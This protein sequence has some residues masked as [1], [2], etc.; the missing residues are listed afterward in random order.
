MIGRTLGLLACGL[1][2]AVRPLAGQVD[3]LIIRP[4][5]TPEATYGEAGQVVQFVDRDLY[6]DLVLPTGSTVEVTRVDGEVIP[7]DSAFTPAYVLALLR[8]CKFPC[9]GGTPGEQR[10]QLALV[11]KILE[12]YP[13]HRDAVEFRALECDLMQPWDGKD[14]PTPAIECAERFIRDYPDD[15]RVDEYVWRI[16]RV[17]NMVYEFE[18][19]V[20]LMRAQAD[21]FEA[22][23][24]DHPD[25]RFADEARWRVAR[26][27]YMMQEVS[28]GEARD[29][30]RA[31]ALELYDSLAESEL[32]WVRLTAVMERFNLEQGRN[33]YVNPN[34]LLVS[35]LVGPF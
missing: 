8:S 18:G 28:R 19:Q 1:V 27:Y 17:R 32:E 14:S 26:L 21:G 15:A 33:I 5:V 20:D 3:G 7:L 9:G 13:N 35:L 31:R 30:Y 25:N 22:F 24:R 6:V 29:R 34:A 4:F 10:N 12:L 23:V 2:V 11:R 16:A